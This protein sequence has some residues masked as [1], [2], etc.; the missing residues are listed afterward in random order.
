MGGIYYTIGDNRIPSLNIGMQ[1][2]SSEI[3]RNLL[4]WRN[5]ATSNSHRVRWSQIVN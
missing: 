1:S 3:L 5:D 4:T 2:N